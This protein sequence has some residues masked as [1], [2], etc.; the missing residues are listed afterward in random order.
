MSRR[1]SSSPSG[2][3][4][5]PQVTR[6]KNGEKGTT[7]SR[8]YW[9]RYC[10]ETGKKVQIA[11][12]NSNGQGIT[13]KAVAERV[14]QKKLEY[15]QRAAAGLID[16][17]IEHAMLPMA[18]VVSQYIDH[19]KA[20]GTTDLHVTKS[21]A[22]IDWVVKQ[23][24]ITRLGEFQADRIVAALDDLAMGKN[25]PATK[26]PSGGA[27]RRSPKTLNEY[28]AA[29]FGLGKWAT[30]V[31]R[32]VPSNPVDG[33]PVRKKG[34]DIRKRRRALTLEQIGR[35]LDVSGS[36]SLWYELA[37]Y[38]G[39]RVSEIRKLQW[40]DLRLDATPPCI[41]LRAETTKAKRE[42][43]IPLRKSFAA[44]LA[45]IRPH[46]TKPTAPVFRSTP[47]RETFRR[48]C[49][50][51]GIDYSPDQR[52]RTID[53]HALRMTFVTMLSVFGVAPR[54]AQKLA[55]HTD[56]K[57]TM[58]VYT[59]AGL[60]VGSEAVE[61]LPEFRAA[62]STSVAPGVAPE[63]VTEGPEASSSVTEALD[64]TA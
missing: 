42:D 54:V 40:G 60:L 15:I 29:L 5:R 47:T 3:V 38:T 51:A 1:K 27:T 22:R 58:N 52:G 59:D 53:R 55:R 8:F 46:N 17:H 61:A 6:T 7:H 14:L 37:L 26:N 16:P 63:C 28:R 13:D 33:V 20:R 21:E 41:E 18:T 25:A 34:N 11:L 62:G 10:D 50:R 24:R 35:L 43:T 30:Q 23:G 36:R 32:Y 9:A 4:Y 2:F 44:K 45:L 49:D 31:A 19:M 48:D 39:L 64:Q 57:L 12:K 56:L